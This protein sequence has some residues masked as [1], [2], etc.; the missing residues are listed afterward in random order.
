MFS[1]TK[2][3]RARSLRVWMARATSSLPVPLSPWIRIVCSPGATRSTSRCSSWIGA[4]RPRIRGA[5]T[6]SRRALLT[7]KRAGSWTLRAAGA[8]LSLEP[9]V[10]L[11]ADGAVRRCQQVV[12]TGQTEGENST[13]KWALRRQVGQRGNPQD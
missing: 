9:S 2:G 1:A 13:V 10:Y 12:L 8:E 11:G 4:L 3:P 5:L 6:C 7:C